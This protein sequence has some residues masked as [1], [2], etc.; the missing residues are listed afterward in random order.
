[1]AAALLLLVATAARPIGGF[2]MRAERPTA[3]GSV[4]MVFTFGCDEPQKATVTGT[5][6]AMIDGERRT[7]PLTLK[8]RSVE[9]MYDVIWT[10]PAEG[11]W[12]LTV[13]GNYRGYVSSLI[14]PIDDSGAAR[15]PEPDEYGRR[16]EPIRRALTAADI[17]SALEKL[18]MAG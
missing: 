2:E 12:L 9:G 1:M 7:V 18:A 13:S 10:K 6:E 14:I 8:P 5:A 11:D 4:L 3:D 15:L 16:I 17:R